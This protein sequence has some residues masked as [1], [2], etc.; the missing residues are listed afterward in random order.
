MRAGLAT[1]AKMEAADGWRALEE[2]TASFA[3][4]LAD[5]LAACGAAV[6]VVHAASIFWLHRRSARRCFR[7]LGAVRSVAAIPQ[8]QASGI[9]VFFHAALDRGVYLPPSGFEVCFLSLAHE[10]RILDEAR[11]ALVEA[12]REAEGSISNNQ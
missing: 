12:A 2:S 7:T 10:R 5:D 6:D 3:R 4:Q 1:L 9:S 11:A 8:G